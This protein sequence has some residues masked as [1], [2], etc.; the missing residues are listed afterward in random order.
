M[1]DSIGNYIQATRRL[2]VVPQSDALD[3]CIEAIEGGNSVLSGV[4]EEIIAAFRSVRYPI[5]IRINDYQ[6]Q[7]YNRRI[8]G[9]QVELRE[10]RFKASVQVLDSAKG[11][12][13]E[14]KEIMVKRA[15]AAKT[16]VSWGKEGGSKTEEVFGL[17]SDELCKKIAFSIV[18]F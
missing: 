2:S 14:G 9:A 16:D 10:I 8:R 3:T 18:E 1:P 12:I 15:F 4:D 5:C 11:I 17:A 7:R 13:K 6:D